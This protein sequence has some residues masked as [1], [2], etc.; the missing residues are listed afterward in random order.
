MKNKVNQQSNSK[1]MMQSKQLLILSVI[2]IGLAFS[3]GLFV[4]VSTSKTVKTGYVKIEQVYEEFDLKKQLSG[5]LSSLQVKRK[6]EMDSLSLQIKMVGNQIRIQPKPQDG[7]VTFYKQL[8]D[9][10]EIR[11]EQYEE[12]ES[13]LS[14]S[15]NEQIINQINRYVKEYGIANNYDII[16]GTDGSGNIMYANESLDITTEIVQYINKKHAG[17][18]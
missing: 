9:E 17:F 6:N 4:L 16:H 3:F 10:Y 8:V 7:E 12:E 15:Y 5:Q 11:S 2:L 1:A 18:N 14:S 13:R